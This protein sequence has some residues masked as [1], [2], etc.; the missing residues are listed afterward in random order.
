MTEQKD[1]QEFNADGEKDKN[2]EAAESER[3]CTLDEFPN[4]NN[5]DGQRECNHVENLDEQEIHEVNEEPMEVPRQEE[6]LEIDEDSDKFDAENEE[7][8]MKITMSLTTKM[9]IIRLK[10]WKVKIKMMKKEPWEEEKE[11]N[12]EINGIL[13]QTQ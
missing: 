7:K 9:E 13:T 8:E 10:E 6:I 11:E 12:Q 1:L 3:N 4:M 2:E 5:P